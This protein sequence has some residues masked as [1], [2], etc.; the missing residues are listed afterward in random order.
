MN[1]EIE[2]E[3]WA[4]WLVLIITL[5][6]G[7]IRILLLGMKGMWLDET[8]SVWL[9]DQSV[10]DMLHWIVKID[11]N[12]PLYYLLLHY[13]VGHYGDTPYYVRLFSALFGT[14]TIPVI[15]LIGKRMSDV[16]VGLSAAVLLSLSTFN[17]Y[18]A[19]EARMYTL[20]TFNA[21]VA[22]YA[23][24][25]LLT[26]PRSTAPMGSQ[27]REYLRSWLTKE[28]AFPDKRI[29]PEH[30]IEVPG[31]GWRAWLYRF[32]SAS[33]HTIETDLAWLAFIIFSAAT[34]LTHNTAVLF[35]AAINI[36]VF[37]LMLI[38]RINKSDSPIAF[39]SPSFGNWMKS[40]IGIFVFWSLWI[41]AFVQQVRRVDQE[42]WLPKPDWD[43]VIQ[44]LRALL[45]A[46]APTQASQIMIWVLCVALF[47][48]LVYYRKKI[49]MFFFLIA[50]FAIPFLGELIVS[51]HRPIFQGRTLIWITIPMLLLL[52]AGIA[53]LR[54][55]F[56]ILMAL[57]LLG[58]NYLFSD[59]DYFRFVQKEDWSTP[60]GYVANFAQEDDLVLFNSNFV[61]IPFNYYFK[62]YE[63][64]YLIQ[65]EKKGIPLD[66]FNYGILE[67]KMTDNDI[68]GLVSLLNGHNRVWLVYSHNDYTDPMGLIPQTL[69]SQMKLTRER[70]Y[71]GGVVQ[72]YETP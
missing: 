10:A 19:Q 67:P 66:L 32:R 48:G 31:T 60:A 6:G 15:Y 28:S 24:V 35:L 34:L 17:I 51:I 56:L 3:D 41:P 30:L 44:T 38:Q 22:I 40:Q 57:G 20:L 68:P 21:A 4:P 13:W 36:F 59:S 72:L 37:G 33:I 64:K 63:E 45:N 53:Q 55:R 39:Q 50:L 23:L 70:E 9:A 43:T 52:A 46:S 61:V 69:A 58:M 11:P 27:F 49:S 1:D 29:N 18:F 47:L 62:A 42:F 54:F 12:P 7:F 2:L 8:V 65:V 25:W 5:F 16:V 14:A 71:Y 26:D